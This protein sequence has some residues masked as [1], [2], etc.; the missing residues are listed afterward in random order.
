M[1]PEQQAKIKANRERALARLR[2]RGFLEPAKPSDVTNTCAKHSEL[3]S[4]VNNT[5]NVNKNVATPAIET[6]ITSVRDATLHA[7]PSINDVESLGD[8][9][10]RDTSSTGNANVNIDNATD[11]K[12]KP[13]IRPS[14]RTSD[15]IEYDFSTMKNLNGGYIN[16]ED[17]RSDSTMYDE[18]SM[19]SKK[20]KTLED[21]KKEQRERRELYDNKPPPIN[22]TD[23]MKCIECKINLEMDPIIDDI[24]KKRVCKSCVKQMP[25]KYSLL[26]KTECKTDYFLTDPELNDVE[27]FH[28][29]E[30]PNPHSGTFARMQLFLRLEIEEFAFKKWG[31][32]EGLDEEWARREKMK[33]DKREKKFEKKI[34]EMR[35]KTR[36]Q[37]FTR[38]IQEK[39][40]GKQHVHNF[41]APFEIKDDE[42]GHKLTKRRCMDCGLETE[43]FLL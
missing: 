6:R 9:R 4:G 13:F 38:R 30:K 34:K 43:E 32:E 25:E 5:I 35:M 23:D 15:Y 19:G 21:W 31:G 7:L 2:Q 40:F 24:F 3:N 16:P 18:F 17:I 10:K 26:T 8:K 41:S 11:H 36:A 29:L 22:V 33:S 42:D 12:A 39:K 28:R 20:Q 37:E 14:I 27:L 1:T